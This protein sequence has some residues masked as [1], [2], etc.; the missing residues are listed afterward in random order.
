MPIYEYQCIQCGERFEVRQAIG[1][2][3]S[4][5]SCPKCHAAKPTKLFS[6]FFSPGSS[7]LEPSG[8]SCPT[9]SSGACGL[10][11]ME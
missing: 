6:S 10:P 8:I 2:G 3:G 7:A 9:C 11:P 5:L 1:E 4:G